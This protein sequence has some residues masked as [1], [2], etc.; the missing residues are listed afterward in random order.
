[1][2]PATELLRVVRDSRAAA[3]PPVPVRADPARRAA[4]RGAWIHP[5]LRCLTRA[6]RR[7]AFGRALRIDGPVD[8]TALHRLLA[9]QAA[10]D[11]PPEAAAP[12]DAVT[13]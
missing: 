11:P 8:T 12:A 4:G 9:E 6:E 7:K 3:G 2:V 1:V 13:E 5:D 10:Q